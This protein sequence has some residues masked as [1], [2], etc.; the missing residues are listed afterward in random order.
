M[1]R[2]GWILLWFLIKNTPSQAYS[3]WTCQWQASLHAHGLFLVCSEDERIY[4]QSPS[5]WLSFQLKLSTALL[6]KIHRRSLSN[7]SALLAHPVGASF[8]ISFPYWGHRNEERIFFLLLNSSST[9]YSFLP[10]DL[11]IPC[12]RYYNWSLWRCFKQAGMGQQSSHKYSPGSPLPE[13]WFQSNA[14]MWVRS[15]I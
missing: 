3:T 13:F 11:I 9:S 4:M 1:D 15:N 2:G 14:E 10:V 12:W 8:L 6:L 7:I 5:V